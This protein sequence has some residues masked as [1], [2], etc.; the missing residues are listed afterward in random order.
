MDSRRFIGDQQLNEQSKP[1]EE[2]WCKGVTN[3]GEVK[4]VQDFLAHLKPTIGEEVEK[5][6]IRVLGPH[7]PLSQ[8]CVL[9]PDSSMLPQQD[10]PSASR[11]LKLQFKGDLPATLFTMTKIADQDVMLEVELLDKS[12]NRVDYGPESSLKIKI[13]VLDGDF[14]VEG[15]NDLTEEYTKNITPPRKDK[16]SLL[17]GNCEIKMSRGVA[18]VSHIAFTDN[19]KSTRSEKYRLGAKI[20]KGLPPGVM[21]MAAVSEAIR[22]K[23]R[24]G[25]SA[26]LR[27]AKQS[28]LP[29]LKTPTHQNSDQELTNLSIIQEPPLLPPPSWTSNVSG[30]GHT[31]DA[32]SLSMG[33]ISP[34]NVYHDAAAA[35]QAC[36]GYVAQGGYFQNHGS[37]VNEDDEK[38]EALI[39]THM[40][41]LRTLMEETPVTT[42]LQEGRSNVTRKLISVFYMTKAATMFMISVQQDASVPRK[43]RKHQ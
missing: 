3:L 21:V 35:N 39:Q 31:L 6:L 12:D 43:K 40:E 10:K 9:P 17:K 37:M 41:M 8:Q 24:R 4:W 30:F 1:P 15:R 18:S 38:M 11:C 22:V 23:E 14:D 20:V 2:C 32:N 26:K 29:K 36:Q 33:S 25:K 27:N 19:S 28:E 5:A 7:L 34:T 13:D 16:G 42:P